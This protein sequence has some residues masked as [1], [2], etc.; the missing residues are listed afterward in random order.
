M[1]F[2]RDFF[3]I[4][5]HWVW[6]VRSKCGL[7]DYRTSNDVFWV[8]SRGVKVSGD[9][10]GNEY[11]GKAPV[12]GGRSSGV[13]RE[14]CELMCRRINDCKSWNWEK[15]TRCTLNNFDL[16]N[17]PD[18]IWTNNFLNQPKVI[19]ISGARYGQKNRNDC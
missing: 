8:L 18:S 3:L 12:F 15:N 11:P 19:S 7:R 16:G 17:Y 10:N 9:S 14:N 13:T 1:N 6:S 5:Q 4:I 2:D